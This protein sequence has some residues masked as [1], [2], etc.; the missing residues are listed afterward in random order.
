M[1]HVGC[2]VS[3]V[4]KKFLKQKKEFFAEK[5]NIH[6]NSPLTI[7]YKYSVIIIYIYVMMCQ[8]KNNVKIL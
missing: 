7:V 8:E 2:T 1:L 6:K 4:I 5:G 3:K